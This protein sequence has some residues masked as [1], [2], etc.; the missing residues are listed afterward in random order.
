MA[1]DQRSDNL[2]LNIIKTNNNAD[3]DKSLNKFHTF[4]QRTLDG[5]TS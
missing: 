3:D 5:T 4:D 2:D 1:K